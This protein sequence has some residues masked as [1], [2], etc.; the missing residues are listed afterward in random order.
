MNFLAVISGNGI[1]TR[2]SSVMHGFTALQP[3]GGW[4][5][6]L[7]LQSATIGRPH[8]A[9][10][11]RGESGAITRSELLLFTSTMY[12]VQRKAS[13]GDMKPSFPHIVMK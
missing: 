3:C 11:L 1:C 5:C 12:A 7:L 13:T 2:D 10:S 9:G 6:Q 8:H 4:R